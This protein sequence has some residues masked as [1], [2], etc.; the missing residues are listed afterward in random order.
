[1]LAAGKVLAGKGRRLILHDLQRNLERFLAGEGKF[2]VPLEQNLAGFLKNSRRGAELVSPDGNLLAV[3]TGLL[4]WT[5]D[6]RHEFHRA[7]FHQR[8]R[9]A[10]DIEF[11]RI[12]SAEIVGQS[13]FRGEPR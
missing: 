3:D 2:V 9:P 8:Y 1:H 4:E 6:V 5:A 7:P 13:D 11:E 10:A 12:G